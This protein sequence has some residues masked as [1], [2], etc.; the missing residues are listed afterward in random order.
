MTTFPDQIEPAFRRGDPEVD[1]KGPEGENVRLLRETY[2]AIV[3]ADLASAL[4]R[5]HDEIDFEITGPPGTPFLGRWRGRDEVGEALARNFG[6]VQDQEPEIRSLTAQGDT[7]VV[8]AHERGRIAATGLPYAL[9][10]VQ[11]FEFRDGRIARIHEV[12]DGYALGTP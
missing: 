8:V 3:R 11:L 7:V 5:L 6:M 10:W 4:G 2:E 9:H 12:I 1:R